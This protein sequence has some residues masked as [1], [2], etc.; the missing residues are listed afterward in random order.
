MSWERALTPQD[1]SVDSHDNPKH[2]IVQLRS[3]KTYQFGAGFALHLGGTGNELCPVAAMLGYLAC[4]PQELFSF[5]DGSPLSRDRL[6]SELREALQL[7]NIN[8][9]RVQ[10]PL[11][12]VHQNRCGYSQEHCL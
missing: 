7:A 10:W 8:N 9:H 1:V 2:L 12:R 5:D 3:S 4:R 6:C 11:F